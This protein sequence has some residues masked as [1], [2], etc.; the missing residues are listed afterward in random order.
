MLPA[1]QHDHAYHALRRVWGDHTMSSARG[2]YRTGTEDHITS[3]L[4]HQWALFPEPNWVAALVGTIGGEAGTVQRVR[5]AYECNETLDASLRPFHGR[6][7]IIPDIILCYEDEAG[8][9]IVACEVKKP[10]KAA[11]LSD[12]RKL[13]SYVNLASV[14]RFTRRYCC[15]IVSEQ[16]A[17][18]TRQASSKRFPVLTWERLRELQVQSALN[19]GLPASNGILVTNDRPPFC[20]LR[21]RFAIAYGAGFQRA[22]LRFP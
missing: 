10:G 22:G 9:A 4:F 17:E 11:K 21:C 2:F 7:F 6:D 1:D 12:A 18:K 5:W 19:V 13:E 16:C 15:F 20:T 8:P 3:T 14:R